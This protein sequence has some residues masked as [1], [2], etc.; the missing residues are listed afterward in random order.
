MSD[1][2][3]H[4][5]MNIIAPV[6][7]KNKLSLYDLIITKD[8]I[9]IFVDRQNGISFEDIQNCI[10]G[11]NEIV[12]ADDLDL[13][14]KYEL[15]VSSPGLERVL[16]KPEHFLDAV[17]LTVSIKT[18]SDSNLPRRLQGVLLSSNSTYCVLESNFNQSEI[19]YDSIQLAKTVFV[20]ED[21]VSRTDLK[22]EANLENRKNFS[23]KKVGELK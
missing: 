2:L 23:D 16:R 13:L 12:S 14:G 8:T 5:V 9:K 1:S 4:S 10:D 20:W 18:K 15:E 11:I 7:E 22:Q 21:E 19:A 3:E 17:G 6:L